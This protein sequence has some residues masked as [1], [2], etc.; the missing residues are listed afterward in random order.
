[1]ALMPLSGNWTGGL[2]PHLFNQP[3]SGLQGNREAAHSSG[4]G[5]PWPLDTVELS[6]S[7]LAAGAGIYQA[8]SLN[9]SAQSL[10]MSWGRGAG[11]RGRGG[12]GA[13]ALGTLNS[14]LGAGRAP[15][16]GAMAKLRESLEALGL[17]NKEI[18]DLLMLA[19]LLEKL[20]PEALDRFVDGIVEMGRAV[21][22]AAAA[23]VM[24]SAP[25]GGGV[26]RFSLEYVSISMSVTEVE[27]VHVE[28]GGGQ[29]TQ[30]SARRF[31]VRF[32]SLRISMQNAGSGVQEGDPLVLDVAGDGLDLKP[33]SEG[34]LFDLTGSGQAV[35][36]AFVQG[37]DAL[38]FYDAN[39]N[40]LLDGGKELVGGAVE[41]LNGFEELA[42]MDENGDGRVDSA[43]S[44]WDLL[45]LFQDENGDGRVSAME[46]KLLAELGLTELSALWTPD[47]GSDGE[48]LRRVGSSS[49]TREDGTRGMMF[50]YY[51]GYRPEPEGQA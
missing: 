36:T 23:P 31:E 11:G 29:V 35:R 4:G 34:V 2:P 44:A 18:R 46:V 15:G 50:D 51:F 48:G 9:L 37:D 12:G 43:D 10:N 25:T 14:M 40:G 3:N 17:G 45:R 19:A 32:E 41:G 27:A 30:I 26:Q 49:F 21:S 6:G 13:S 42:L 38:L 33:T 20:D 24:E 39:M 5:N 7:P 1:M 22:G 28:E 47:A 8:S 16:G